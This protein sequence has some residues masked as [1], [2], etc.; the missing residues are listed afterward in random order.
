MAFVSISKASSGVS[1]DAAWR[2]VASLARR[3]YRLIEVAQQRRAQAIV[4]RY[5]RDGFIW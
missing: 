4:E 3:V 1:L 2:R 5:Q